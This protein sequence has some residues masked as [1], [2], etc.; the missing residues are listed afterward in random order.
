[1]QLFCFDALCRH[2]AADDVDIEQLNTTASTTVHGEEDD[3]ETEEMAPIDIDAILQQGPGTMTTSAQQSSSRVA[4]SAAT[5]ISTTV[6]VQEPEL[7][8]LSE[9]ES[10]TEAHEKIVLPPH[11]KC[12]CHLLNLVASADVTK[13]DGSVKRIS[14]Q[15]FSKLSA[16]WN[17]Q[18]R[19]SLAAD[20]I[21]AGLGV[22]LITPGDTRWNATYDAVSHVNDL[23]SKPGLATEF[24][25]VCDDLDIPKLL[26]T[27]K[28]FIA[29][30]VRVFKPVCDGLDVLQGDKKVGLGFL[31]PT[32]STMLSK[33]DNLLDHS[34]ESNNIVLTICEPLV[35]A[36]KAG[37]VK[38]FGDVLCDEE[39]KLAA[40]LT[41]KFKLDWIDLESDKINITAKLES[42]LVISS[43]AQTD[44]T[45]AGLPGGGGE[46][47]GATSGSSQ[48]VTRT[49]DFF[50]DIAAKRRRLQSQDKTSD[51]IKYLA[52]ADSDVSSLAKYPRLQRLYIQLNTGLPASAAVERLFS[53]GGRVF[54]PLRSRMT[55]EHFE[56]MVFMRLANY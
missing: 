30:Y 35:L 56:M 12:A 27:H 1:M 37:I 21:R 26:P 23:L 46:G 4:L 17:K 11:R 45:G 54:S 16:L 40:V 53:L 13:M 15:V 2:F 41:P 18:N 25:K 52:D 10:E 55:P 14:T 42:R 51:V 44:D 22:L 32:L 31:V 29:E 6:Q 20:R 36:L 19:T 38:R 28:R 24:D 9:A 5:S 43:V 48:T 34:P 8:E 39:A 47:S 50:A 33:L 7:E 49:D 3:D